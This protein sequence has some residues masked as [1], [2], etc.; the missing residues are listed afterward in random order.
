MESNLYSELKYHHG[1]QHRLNQVLEDAKT[2][3]I[4]KKRQPFYYR[5]FRL[6]PRT[7][8]KW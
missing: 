6:K 8:P 1:D 5:F 7:Q 3:L 2:I 4:H